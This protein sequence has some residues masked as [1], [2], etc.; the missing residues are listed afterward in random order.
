MKLPL[1]L[2]TS[3]V[4]LGACNSAP[5]RGVSDWFADARDV[6]VTEFGRSTLCGT[7]GDELQ[8]TMFADISRFETWREQRGVEFAGFEQ[9]GDDRVVV[10]EQG[11]RPTAGY[12]VAVSRVARVRGTELTLHVT[13][14]SPRPGALAAQMITAPC[15]VVGVPRGNYR[16]VRVLDQSGEQR[17][18]WYP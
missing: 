3:A 17:G 15:V 11:Q 16:K 13:L 9:A 7:E 10:I 18:V 12:Q 6:N 14:L 2:V 5:I 4:M 8:V 1:I